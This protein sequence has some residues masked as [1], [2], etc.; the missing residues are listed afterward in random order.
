VKTAFQAFGHA[1]PSMPPGAG[2]KDHEIA[3]QWHQST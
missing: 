1:L 3:R 2:L